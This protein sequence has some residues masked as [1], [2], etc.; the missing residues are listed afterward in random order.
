[1]PSAKA[2]AKK[3]PMAVSSRIRPPRATSG[4]SEGGDRPATSAPPKMLSA[5]Q[6]GE[7]DAGEDGVADRVADEGKAPHDDV[8]TDR[9]AGRAHHHHLG[10]RAQDEVVA[11]RV[12]QPAHWSARP[13]V[14]ASVHVAVVPGL[15]D[16]QLAAE[17]GVE[18]ARRERLGRRTV[19]D[20]AAV[21][22]AELVEISAARL[23]VVGGV[24]DGRATVAELLQR[25][26][27]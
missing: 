13:V 15:H 3:M 21:D 10:Q 11:E 9:A 7:H 23:E 25:G 20:D 6:V 18:D 24:Q 17:G 4:D 26:R 5:R 1:M 27:R 19:G 2:A 16:Q 14:A 22:E 12:G 8:R